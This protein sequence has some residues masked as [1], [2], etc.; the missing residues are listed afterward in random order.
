MQAVREHEALERRVRLSTEAQEALPGLSALVDHDIHSP[1]LAHDDVFSALTLDERLWEEPATAGT[2]SVEDPPSGQDRNAADPETDNV[3]AQYLGEVRQFALLRFAEEQALARRITRWQ[4][5]VRWALYTAPMALPTLRRL[6]HQ[7]EHEEIPVHEVVQAREGAT[8]DPAA[9]GEAFRQALVHLQDLAA[10]LRRLDTHGEA[11]RWAA[12]ARRGRCHEPFR[13]WRAWLTACETLRLHPRVHA[14]LGEALEATW[15]TQPEDPALHAAYRAWTRAQKALE[16]A[17]AQMMQ[18]NLRLVMHIAMRF[19]GRG[20]PL[21]DLIQE[22]NLGLMRAVDKFEPRRGLKFVTYAH[23]WIR[24]A[25]SRALSEQHR[26]VRLPSHVIERQSK[27]RAAATKWWQRYG[28]APSPQEL[29]AALG[30]TPEAVDE[31]LITVQP[32]VQ[33]QQ[34][35]TDDGTALQDILE[36]TQTPPPDMLVAAEHVRRGVRACLGHLTAR[37]A[38]IVRL[39]YGLD[40]DEPHSLQ[41]IGDVLGIS[42]ER[43]RQLEKQAFAKLRQLPQSAVLAELAR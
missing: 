33:L 41:D 29:S 36:D 40:A 23:W 8:P 26:T 9:Q 7:V 17:K 27:L 3:I 43:V 12:Q 5:R 25:I 2:S 31:L 11:P 37:E 38:L 18:A 10:H 42:R 16:E 19:R 39:R 28:H 24:Q 13:L 30:W 14:A 21:L 22:G 32:M 20:V 4:R 6:W 34:P 35:I 15:R 1:T